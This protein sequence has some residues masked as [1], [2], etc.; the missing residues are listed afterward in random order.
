MGKE[1]L[2]ALKARRVL[3]AIEGKVAMAD[4][5]ADAERRSGITAKLREE[6]LAREAVD[7]VVPKKRTKK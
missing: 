4:Y 6:R 2:D 3:Q 5:I 7:P 1:E